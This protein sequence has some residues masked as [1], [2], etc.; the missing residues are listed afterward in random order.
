MS[1]VTHAPG[2]FC[3][4]ELLT[5]DAAAAKAF[6]GALLGLEFR[7]DPMPEGGAYTMMSIADGH[8]GGMWQ[9]DDAMK[10]QGVVSHWM[11]YVSVADVDATVAKARELGGVVTRE[12]FDVM[13]FGRMAT[14]QD[15]SK[16]LLSVWQAGTHHGFGHAEPR[17]GT[18]CWNELASHNIDLCGSFY[19][20]LFA[21]SPKVQDMGGSTY[22]IFKSGEDMRAGM[23]A[24]DGDDYKDIPS[25][26][27]LYFMVEDCLRSVAKA[28]ELGATVRVPP[29]QI[30]NM[31]RFSIMSDPTG[32]V[33]SVV[34]SYTGE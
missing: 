33:F 9:I 32:A 26:W 4:A 31:G 1:D 27:N 22:T 12:P 25:H 16:A 11:S 21:W 18:V 8:V 7:D 23:M 29:T 17:A 2:K 20:K 15:P 34:D 30:P 19:A 13:E 10:Q 24:M 3:W 5:T 14:F 28:R 6:Y